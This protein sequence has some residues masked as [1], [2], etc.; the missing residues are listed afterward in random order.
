L[1]LSG[2]IYGAP[3]DAVTGRLLA[4]YALR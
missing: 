1:D 2:E 3:G 4:S